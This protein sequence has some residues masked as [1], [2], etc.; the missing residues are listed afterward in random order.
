MT[1][2]IPVAVALDLLSREEAEAVVRAC[3]AAGEPA[4]LTVNVAGSVLL[5]PVDPGDHVFEASFN[6]RRR[7][8]TGKRRPLGVDAIA[9][10]TELFRSAGWSVR[11]EDSSVRLDATDGARAREWLESWVGAAVDAR[12]ALEE[13]AAE[14]LQTRARQL[15][16]GKLRI[17]LRRQDIVA[18]SP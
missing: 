15:A 2:V 13:W 3:V 18:W 11:V 17:E 9:T 6:D 7:R 8:T 5:D 1:G 10:V 14:Y 12:P 4:L 16:A